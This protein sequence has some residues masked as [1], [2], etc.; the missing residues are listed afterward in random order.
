MSMNRLWNPVRSFATRSALKNNS[1]GITNNNYN[2]ITNTTT[3]EQFATMEKQILDEY[4]IPGKF[5]RYF[6]AQKK[7]QK[8]L[9]TA[10]TDTSTAAASI[11]AGLDHVHKKSARSINMDETDSAPTVAQQRLAQRIQRG[12]TKVFAIEPLPTRWVTPSYVSIHTVKASRNLRK[13]Q[14]LYE[15]ATEKKHE[16]GHV[17]RALQTHASCLEQLI[18]V[19]AG[20]QRPVSIKFVSDTQ[21]SEL[22]AI[23][24][25][26]SAEGEEQEEQ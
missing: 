10:S 18:R 12:L 23:F 25:K 11:S 6:K 26:I 8:S 13:C 20:L 22:D 9:A 14:I 3:Q 4:M 5:L 2:K 21:T 15:P 1:V 19:H 24:K 16:R 7:L 17:H